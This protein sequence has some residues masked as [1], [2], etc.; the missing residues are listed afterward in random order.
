VYALTSGIVG[1]STGGF[2]L[3]AAG[4]QVQITDV[5]N[6]KGTVYL[7]IANAGPGAVQIKNI[8]LGGLDIHN[9]TGS[10]AI[11]SGAHGSP[12]IVVSFSSGAG[13]STAQSMV[14]PAGGK[15]SITISYSDSMTTD[16]TS[17]VTYS[18]R[19]HP[20]AGPDYLFSVQA[21]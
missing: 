19:V 2:N 18:G 11:I 8:T 4:S 1:S 12:A 3:A 15:V 5:A 14:L 13:P 7:L 6:G 9:F 17:G 21:Q 20:I 10:S 16:F